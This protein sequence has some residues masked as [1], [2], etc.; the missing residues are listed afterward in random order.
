MRVKIFGSGALLRKLANPTLVT[1]PAASTTTAKSGTPS[2]ANSSGWT[3]V[4]E[5]PAAIDKEGLLDSA[6]LRPLAVLKNQFLQFRANGLHLVITLGLLQGGA[7]ESVQNAIRD[8]S[9]SGVEISTR[10][11]SDSLH[12]RMRLLS[13][14]GSVANE[15]KDI[16]GPT[17]I[18]LALR[19]ALG[20][21]RYS[22]L[23]S[24]D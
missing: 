8:L 18:G 15:W 16:T 1:E 17:E 22:Q 3:I 13:P 12:A 24:P 14:G 7:E 11:A 2:Q 20:S 6:S 19:K 23:R 4:S 9:M 10:A 21:P 5:I